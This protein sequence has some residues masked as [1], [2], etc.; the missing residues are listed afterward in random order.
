MKHANIKTI[1]KQIHFDGR[2]MHQTEYAF[3]ISCFV[4]LYGS[5]LQRI[6]MKCQVIHT[7]RMQLLVRYATHKTIEDYDVTFETLASE[8]RMRST[9]FL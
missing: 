2:V 8:V 5:L 6:L 3:I 9:A 7:Q 4:T 1:Y